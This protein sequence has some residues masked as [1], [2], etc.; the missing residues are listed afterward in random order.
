[1]NRIICAD[2]LEALQAMPEKSVSMCVTSPPYYGLRDYGIDGQI[3]IEQ[4]PQ[5]YIAGLITI[6]RE[7]RRVLRDDGTLWVNIADSYAG[8]GKGICQTPI[9]ERA[10]HKQTY[11]QGSLAGTASVPHQWDGIKPKDLIGIPWMLAF[12]LRADGWFL[13][14][15]IIWQKINALP[16]S[17]RDRPTKSYEHIFLL[18]KSPRYYYDYEAI[19]EPL[20]TTSVERYKRGRSDHHKYVNFSTDQPINH[21]D[22]GVKQQ[23]R[24]KRNKRDVWSLS[25]NSIRV[26][27]HFAMF[28]EHLVEPCIAAGSPVGG[29]VLDPFCGSGTTGIVAQRMG[30]DFVGIDI[31]P[32]YCEK[33][34]Q[35][36]TGSE[37]PYQIQFD[38]TELQ[39]T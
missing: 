24:M 35:R 17:V 9:S 11:V 3:G 23:G 12:A 19:M 22:Y 13:R 37:L 7:V 6:F 26:D 16:E 8:S 32:E 1:M 18:A 21:S 14:S 28:P 31:N 10:K 29:V 38:D 15:D 33:A 34:I 39:W 4:S 27:G 25:T 20:A 30:R 5:K 36:I 2:A